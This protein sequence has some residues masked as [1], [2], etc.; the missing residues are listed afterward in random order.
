[1]RSRTSCTSGTTSCAVHLDRRVARRAQGDVQHGA[2]LGGVDA[3]AARTSRRCARAGRAARPGRRAAQRLVRDPVLGV[4]EEQARALGGQARPAI[5]IRRRTAHAG[6]RRG[7]RRGGAR[8]AARRRARGGASGSP[9]PCIATGAFRARRPGWWRG[10]RVVHDDAADHRAAFPGDPMTYV[11]SDGALRRHALPPRT[12]RSG[13]QL[14]GRVARA[15]AQ[16]RRRQ[17]ARGPARGAAT[18]VRPRGHP[19]RPGQQLRAALRR[20]RGQLRPA[21]SREDFAALPRR[22]GHLDQGGLGHVARP[23]RLRRLAQVPAVEPRPEPA[24]HGPRLRRHLLLAPLRPRHADRGD[25]GRAR[26]GRAPGQGAV[27][28]ISSYSA[29][30]TEEAVAILRD[31]GTPLLIHQPNY[32]MFNRWIEGGLLDVLGRARRRLHRASRR[33]PRA[34]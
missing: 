6:G 31:L 15:L 11:P 32:S 29:E 30:R 23:V 10:G 33:W 2:V 22:A 3:L 7:L 34:C 1:M 25:D 13:L 18:R 24:A 12:G 27:R 17:A 26:R 8:A 28:R 5:G 4:V 16:L 21:S 19:L 14:P 20:G 9:S